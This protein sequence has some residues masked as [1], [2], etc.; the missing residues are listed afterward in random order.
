MYISI[1]DTKIEVKK[2]MALTNAYFLFSKAC[3]I[4][5]VNVKK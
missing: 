3:Q 5:P 1:L 2:I 4:M